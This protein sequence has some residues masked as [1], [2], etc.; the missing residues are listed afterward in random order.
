MFIL[1]YRIC[2]VHIATGDF[3]LVVWRLWLQSANLMN[4][5]TTYNHVY[6]EATYTQCRPEISANVQIIVPI[7]QT[8][9]SPN[10][11][12]FPYNYNCKSRDTQVLI[13]C[14]GIL[15]INSGVSC[16]QNQSEIPEMPE[17]R[18][19]NPRVADPLCLWHSLHYGVY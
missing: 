11:P 2:A 18:S 14:T 10:I 4:A 6:Y 13:W 9:C 1:G 5:N 16:M 19:E 7:P 15:K 3:N 17:S 8:Y 12:R